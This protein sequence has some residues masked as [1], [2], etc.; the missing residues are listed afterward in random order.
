MV[1]V[2]F[3]VAGLTIFLSILL[4]YKYW[5][6]SCDNLKLVN[7]WAIGDFIIMISVVFEAL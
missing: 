3:F 1:C 6:Y 5:N 7:E 4:W 2:C